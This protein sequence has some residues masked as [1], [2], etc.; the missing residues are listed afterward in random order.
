MIQAKN[1]FVSISVNRTRQEQQSVT[2]SYISDD[3]KVLYI[4]TVIEVTKPVFYE[5]TNNIEHY[6][7]STANHFHNQQR[8]TMS[9]HDSSCDEYDNKQPSQNC[10]ASMSNH[11]HSKQQGDSGIELD[12]TS[13]S[14]TIFNQRTPATR[15]GQ[16]RS[17]FVPNEVLSTDQPIET[18]L[19]RRFRQT[20]TAKLVIPKTQQLPPRSPCPKPIGRK[21]LISRCFAALFLGLFMLLI[22]FAIYIYNLDRCSRSSLFHLLKNTIIRVERQGIPLI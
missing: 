1:V 6:Y 19:L 2:T 21:S 18:S 15:P 22:V 17:C 8:L 7:Q 5:R 16:G 20:E 9:D 12:K 10:S 3:C 13:S 4:E 11:D 14:S